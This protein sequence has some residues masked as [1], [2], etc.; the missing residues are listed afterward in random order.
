MAQGSTER[1][2]LRALK[3][4]ASQALARGRL[5]TALAGFREAVQ[6]A[7]EDVAARKKV[8][9]ILARLDHK[10]EAIAEYQHLVGRFAA[11]GQLL[12]AMALCKVILQLDPRHT[13]TQEALANLYTRRSDGTHWMNKLPPSMAG[14][15]VFHVRPEPAP[16]AAPLAP[17]E[18][19]PQLSFDEEP[20][21]PGKAPSRPSPPPSP[22]EV[23]VNVDDAPPTPLFSDLPKEAFLAA[24]DQVEMRTVPAGTRILTEGERGTSMFILVQGAVDVVR[25]V[26]N[27]EQ[28]PMARLSE[29]SFFGE[30]G[31][32]SDSPRIASVVATQECTLLELSREM[33]GALTQRFPAVDP[34]IQ[35]FYRERLLANLLR[36][37]PLFQP[38]T[39]GQKQVVVDRFV[40]RSVEKGTVLVRQGQPSEGMHL[41]LRGRCEVVHEDLDGSEKRYPDMHEGAVFGEIS[42]LLG[43]GATATVRAAAPCVVLTLDKGAFNELIMGNPEAK[44]TLTRMVKERLKRTAELLA[45]EEE[46]VWDSFLL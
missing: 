40:S 18:E 24:I 45:G 31:L 25:A 8:A 43:S 3:D 44:K 13:A 1:E 4:S 39:P 9:E 46:S 38:L 23:E 6:L 37:S 28:R 17:P 27:G 14:A 16:A 30:M 5:E 20:P 7:P 33:I 10:A 36:S 41:L 22:A 12:Q 34:I 15:L 21:A 35:R 29:G 19:L 26:P 11:E 2:R 42:L 32:L